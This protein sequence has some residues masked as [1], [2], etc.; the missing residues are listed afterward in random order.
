MRIRAL[1]EQRAKLVADARVLVD[2]DAVSTEEQAKFDEMMAEVDK[3]KA[4]I[5]ALERA[6]AAEKTL[7]QRTAARAAAAGI[8]PAEQGDRSADAIKVF[9]KWLRGGLN[10]LDA[11]ERVQA[12]GAMSPVPGVRAAQ[13]VGTGS[14]GGYT[15][16]QEFYDELEIALKQYGGMLDVATVF[17]TDSGADMPVPSANDTA[18]SGAIVAENA[19]QATQDVTFGTLTLKSYMYSSKI[20]LVS[21]QLMQDSAFDISSFLS[22]IIGERLGRILNSHF[23]TGTGSSQPNGLVTAGTVGRTAATGQTTSITS[24]DEIIRTFHSLDPA[25][26]SAAR[27]MM[28]DA[29][30]LSVRLLKDTTNQYLWQPA[31][32]Q[33]MPD[34]LMGKPVLINQDM[35]TMAANAK[36]IA[37]G[38]FSKYLIRRARGIQVMRLDER[39]ADALQVAFFGFA[40]FDGNLVDAGTNPVKLFQNSAT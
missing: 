31:L 16:P 22:R 34:L 32:A 20:I 33:G 15:V 1:R 7:G 30:A 11:D 8:S 36:P 18:Q 10:A 14:A 4:Q 6:E 40:R 12:L 24:F 37:F 13:S 9:N 21:L 17:D 26:R 35:P 27:W 2:K 28:N 25:Y 39:Y 38:D 29:T 3:L 5:D 23:T 19:A